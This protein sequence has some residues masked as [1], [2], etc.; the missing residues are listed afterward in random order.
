MAGKKDKKTK[1]DSPEETPAEGEAGAEGAKKKLSGKTLVLFI[2][3][4]AVLVLGGGGAAAMMLLGGKKTEVAAAEGEHGAESKASEKKSKEKAAKDSHGAP[5]AGG[6]GEGATPGDAS[7]EG[8]TD[9][10]HALD[11]EDGDPCYYSMPA[12]MVNLSA[13]EGQRAPL[14]KL[15]LV[16]EAKS[17]GVFESVPQSMPRLKDQFNTFLRELRVEDLDGTAG[18]FRLRQELLRRFNIVMAPAQIDAVLVEGILI[19]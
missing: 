6:H 13:A 16:L 8:D 12:L 11:C 15:D 4:P 18:T 3:L 17:P 5:A 14:M 7:A 10:G 1:T 9:V 19:Q 2:V